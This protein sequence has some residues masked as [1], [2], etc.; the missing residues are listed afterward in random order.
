M[1]NDE[2]PNDE[3]MTKFQKRAQNVTRDPLSPTGG[4]GQ[5]EG[6]TLLSFGLR[7][8]FVIRPSSFVILL[9]FALSGFGA[10]YDLIIRNGRLI[11]GTGNPA[12]FADVALTNG[13]LAAVFRPNQ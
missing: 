4:E 13:R 7:A 2:N 11:D 6:A 5:G 10:T 8:S 12:F 1:T 9:L 3:R